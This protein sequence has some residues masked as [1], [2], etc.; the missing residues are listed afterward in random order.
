MYAGP[1]PPVAK[2]ERRTPEPTHEGPGVLRHHMVGLTGF[3]PAASSSRTRRATKLRHSPIAGPGA[4]GRQARA[5]IPG[6]SGRLRIAVSRPEI[7]PGESGSAGSP[8]GG[9]RPGTVRT[10][11]CRARP[12]RAARRTP[13]L[14]AGVCGVPVQ[15]LGAGRLEVAVGDQGTDQRHADLAAVG[16]A[17]EDRLVAVGGVLVEHPEVRRV[18]HADAEVG[19]GVGRPADRDQV[20]VGQVGVVDARPRDGQLPDRRGRRAGWSGRASRRRR[21]RP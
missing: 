3:E 1:R 15:P 21:R 16:V 18:G 8:R 2:P 6:A 20:V 19:R 13:G 10:A 7:R 17:G 14:R 11:T 5:S 4:A 9:R 12:R